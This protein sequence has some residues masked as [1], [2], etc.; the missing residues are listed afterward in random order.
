MKKSG[1]KFDV[2]ELIR[3]TRE[4]KFSSQKEFWKSHEATLK[5]SY[6]HYSAVENSKKFPDIQLTIAVSK[7]LGI[8]LKLATSLWARDQMPDAQTRSFF[9]PSLA[10]DSFGGQAVNALMLDDFYVF[11]ASQVGF[12][13]KHRVVWPMA[14]YIASFARSDGV[15]KSKV[16]KVFG[17]SSAEFE[18]YS[19]WLVEQGI[20]RREGQVLRVDT[21]YLHLPNTADFKELR[22]KNF[23]EASQDVVAK[24]TMEQ[25]TKRE[26]Y[27]TTIHRRLTRRQAQDVHARLNEVVSYV[28]SLDDVGEECFV[29]ALGLGARF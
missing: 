28:G 2:S 13:M 20:A 27:R 10:E 4:R 7:I 8:D 21:A 29:L 15:E 6:P 14:T 1:P 11:N 9:G 22:D 18:K 12:M 25:L 5:V 24:I 16:M 19:A 3:S 23:L 26:A 17:I